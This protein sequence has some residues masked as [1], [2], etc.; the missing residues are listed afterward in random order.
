MGNLREKLKYSGLKRIVG[1]NPDGTPIYSSVTRGRALAD[2]LKA[3]REA[4]S[5]ERIRQKEV[6]SKRKRKRKRRSFWF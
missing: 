6:S 4:K 3:R 2:Y 1:Q 5:Q